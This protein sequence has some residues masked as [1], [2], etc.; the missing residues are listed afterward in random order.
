MICLILL[1]IFFEWRE[2]EKR[3]INRYKILSYRS[4]IITTFIILFFKLKNG[5]VVYQTGQL[6]TPLINQTTR[7]L[8][9][10][11]T[12]IIYTTIP[13]SRE[14]AFVALC[15]IIFYSYRVASVFLGGTYQE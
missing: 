13:F 14:L 9:S 6:V 4:V 3:N 10:T 7:E 12:Q 15:F 1:M 11:T 8:I 5:L 2:L